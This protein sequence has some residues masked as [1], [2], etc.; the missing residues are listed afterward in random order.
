MIKS[1]QRVSPVQDV[2]AR[3]GRG[4]IVRIGWRQ[5][6]SVKRAQQEARKTVVNGPAVDC[7]IQLRLPS[8]ANNGLEARPSYFERKLEGRFNALEKDLLVTTITTK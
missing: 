8:G 4:R 7:I 5:A 2:N 6:D 3:F 1:W